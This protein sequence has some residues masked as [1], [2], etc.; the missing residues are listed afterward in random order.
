[1]KPLIIPRIKNEARK[2]PF[3]RRKVTLVEATQSQSTSADDDV[4]IS[5]FKVFAAA[6]GRL[7]CTACQRA[8]NARPEGLILCARYVPLQHKHQ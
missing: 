5:V 6:G 3:K 2:P 1:M 4:R 8:I 7:A